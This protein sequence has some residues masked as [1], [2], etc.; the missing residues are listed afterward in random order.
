MHL[1]EAAAQAL[2]VEQQLQPLALV[3]L[4]ARHQ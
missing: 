1:L 4:E 2:L 3:V